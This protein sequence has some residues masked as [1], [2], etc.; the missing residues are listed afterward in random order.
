MIR[1]LLHEDAELKR[2]VQT[3]KD[4]KPQFEWSALAAVSG[5]GNPS[6]IKVRVGEDERDF[7][8]G[9][10]ADTVG[11]AITDLLLARQ[12][13]KEIYTDENRRLVKVISRAVTSDL[14]ARAARGD[15]IP[16][17][18]AREINEVIEQALVRHNAHDVARS[19]AYLDEQTKALTQYHHDIQ[20]PKGVV[21]NPPQEAMA[22]LCQI[23]CSSNRF[24]YI[25]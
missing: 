11:G 13:E 6:R 18:S 9:E 1:N 20:H 21:P 16:A 2:Y 7:D 3:P 4:Q 14:A 10:I 5:E 8:V 23:L 17:I 25:E 12:R 22:S 24:L 15:G 19:L